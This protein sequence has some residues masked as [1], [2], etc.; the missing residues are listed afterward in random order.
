MSIYK[1]ISEIQ[2]NLVRPNSQLQKEK[3]NIIRSTGTR[4]EKRVMQMMFYTNL[5]NKVFEDLKYERAS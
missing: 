5:I 4:K 1:T 3:E 2:A